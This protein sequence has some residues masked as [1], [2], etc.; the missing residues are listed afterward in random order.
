[1]KSYSRAKSYD[2]ANRNY[3]DRWAINY[4][5]GRISE[6]FQYTQE[7]AIAKLKLK[8]DAQVLDVG[9]G[10]GYAV[11]RLAS[12]LSEGKACGI[13]VS[14]EMVAKASAKV[15]NVLLQRVEFVQANSDCIPYAENQFSHV[16]CTNSFHHYPEP[17]HCL[18]EMRRVLKPGGQ[19]VILENAPD[20]SWYTQ[21]WDWVLRLTEKGHIRYYTSVE[22]GEFVKEAGFER[23]TLC[24]LR[25]E[26]LHHGKFYASIQVWT[27]YVPDPKHPEQAHK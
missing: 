1:M 3:F 10:T 12:L 17:I 8:S 6:W 13:D 16:L 21:A 4:D 27:G 11:L 15:P 7:L 18:G 25:N 23:A 14:T 22:L 2:L 5:N 19:I 24:H 9:C 26:F 20:L